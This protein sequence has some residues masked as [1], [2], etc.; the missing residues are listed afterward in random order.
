MVENEKKDSSVNEK[1]KQSIL[2]LLIKRHKIKMILVLFFAL[3]AN[4]YAWFIYNKIVSSDISAEIKAWNVSFEGVEDGVLTFDLDDMYPGMPNHEESVSLTNNGDLNA[5]VNFTLHS[6]DILGES[7]SIEGEEGYSADDLLQ[8]LEERYPF[9]VTFSSSADEVD[10]NGGKV[11]LTFKVVWPYESGNDV[12][13]TK[14]G[15]LAYEFLNN[16]DNASKKCLTIT[17]DVNIVQVES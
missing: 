16:P 6:F 11:D 4:T 2:F 13:D 12:L 8:I 14:Y 5:K 17:L 7:Y 3:V 1:K 9:K 10:S 15:Q